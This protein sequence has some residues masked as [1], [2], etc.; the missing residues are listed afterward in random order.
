MSDDVLTTL[1]RVFREVFN[2]PGLTLHER[3]T[4]HEVKGWDSLKHVELM[5]SVETAFGIRFKTAEMASLENVGALL[6]KL[7]QKLGR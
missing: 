5:L 2:A 3:M 1:E 7:R 6:A 4:A